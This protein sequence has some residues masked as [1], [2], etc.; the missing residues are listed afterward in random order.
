MTGAG[1]DFQRLLA[2]DIGKEKRIFWSEVAVGT[3]IAF[4]ASVRVIAW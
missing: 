1:N 2:E 3:A 4:P